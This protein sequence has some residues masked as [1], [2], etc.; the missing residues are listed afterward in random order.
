MGGLT[1]ALCLIQAGIEV[2]LLEQSA[3]FAEV[4]AGLQISPNGMRVLKALDLDAAV[5]SYAFAPRQIE[6][7]LGRA[8]A[9]SSP[10][11]WRV[12]P[13]HATARPTCTCTGPTCSRCW[14]GP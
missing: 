8:A 13:W 3:A 5:A 9:R 6:M 1:T 4:G 11:R 10:C 14:S 12:P 7:R 2:E